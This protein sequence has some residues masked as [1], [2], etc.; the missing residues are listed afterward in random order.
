MD[1]V[2]K[3]TRSR[4]MRGIK[5]KDTRPELAVRSLAHRMGYRFRLHRRELPGCP[6]LIFPSRQKVIFVHGCYW[7]RHPGCKFAYSPK[8]RIEFWS[9]KFAS[10]VARDAA[11]ITSLRE[12]GWDPMVIWECGSSATEKLGTKLLAHLGAPQ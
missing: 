12:A 5:S 10:N 9:A 6:D 8:S 3:E 2:D 4:M 11:A 1:I 7:H